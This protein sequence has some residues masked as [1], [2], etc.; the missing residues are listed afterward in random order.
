MVAATTNFEHKAQ[1]LENIKKKFFLKIHSADMVVGAL[2]PIV[3]MLTNELS[4]KQQRKRT[5]SVPTSNDETKNLNLAERSNR[6]A[7][8]LGDNAGNTENITIDINPP[9]T[10]FDAPSKSPFSPSITV[11]RVFFL[12]FVFLFFLF[13]LLFFCM[14]KKNKCEKFRKFA[15]HTQAHTNTHTHTHT[16]YIHI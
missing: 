13:F 7:S 6:A 11:Y 12:F 15:Q 10:P 9:I 16:I 3:T 4:T 5:Q 2:A 1:R 14:Q 8:Q